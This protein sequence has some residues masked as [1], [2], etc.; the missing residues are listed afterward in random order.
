M[1]LKFVTLFSAL[2]LSLNLVALTAHAKGGPWGL[3]VVVGEP[4]GFSAQH[5]IDQKSSMNFI[6]AYSFNSWFQISGDYIFYFPQLWQKVTQSN[7][8][9]MPYLGGGIALGAITTKNATDSIALAVRVPFGLEYLIP[10]TALRV[11]GELVPSMRFVP[12]TGLFLQGG[13]GIRIHF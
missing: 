10:D 8:H 2:A 9:V 1:K 7:S 3:G 12:S 5:R 4:T 6:L 11:F 13:V